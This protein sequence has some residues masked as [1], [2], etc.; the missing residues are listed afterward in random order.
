LFKQSALHS[1][2]GLFDSI[3]WTTLDEVRREFFDIQL[4][5]RAILNTKEEFYKI[6]KE[7]NLKTKTDL[8]SFSGRN[9]KKMALKY[10]VWNDFPNGKKGN[11]SNEA[12]IEMKNEA[13]KYN[14]RNEF[15]KNSKRLYSK[16]RYYNIIDGICKHMIS[17]KE[18]WM[19]GRG[20][21]KKK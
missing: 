12:F 8:M 17:Y 11:L 19:I 10:N 9:L 6:V 7:N 4:R 2:D 5:G 13:L 16:A 3:A 18:A 1:S 15:K 21:K 14:S 20:F